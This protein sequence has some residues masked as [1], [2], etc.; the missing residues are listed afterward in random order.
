MSIKK[1]IDRI[2]ER[3]AQAAR[4]SGRNPEDITIIAVSKTVDAQRAKE[5]VKGEAGPVYNSKTITTQSA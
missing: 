5:A 1:N 3:T 2:L 4:R